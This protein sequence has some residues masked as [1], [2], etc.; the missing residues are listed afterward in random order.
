MKKFDVRKVYEKMYRNMNGE[1]PFDFDKCTVIYDPAKP[2]EREIELQC[3]FM[4]NVIKV[5]NGALTKDKIELCFTA[6]YYVDE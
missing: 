2:K 6:T 4:T 5:I 3:E 1:E